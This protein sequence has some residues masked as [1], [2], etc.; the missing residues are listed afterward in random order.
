V[1]KEGVRVEHID[2]TRV[3]RRQ[4][5]VDARRARAVAAARTAARTATRTATR[6]ASEGVPMSSCGRGVGERHGGGGRCHGRVA[7]SEGVQR[8]AGIATPHTDR[9]VRRRGQQARVVARPRERGELRHGLRFVLFVDV[10]QPAER[11]A[12]PAFGAHAAL[13]S[14]RA[15]ARRLAFQP[16]QP[17][18]AVARAAGEP[19]AVGRPSA[20]RARCA[21][22]AHAPT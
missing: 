7:G 2:L 15:P 9:A 8:R 11:D 16:P 22:R 10:R 5:R 17:R 21:A 18:C 4:R 6:I 20:W 13:G 1:R 19:R 14:E 3:R 12:P